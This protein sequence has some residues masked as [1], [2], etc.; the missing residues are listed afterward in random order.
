MA[1]EMCSNLVG[2]W[3]CGVT[4]GKTSSNGRVTVGA[5]MSNGGCPANCTAAVRNILQQCIAN[6]WN[7]GHWQL[8]NEWYWIITN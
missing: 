4:Y 7:N 6:K 1:D 2:Q 3:R 8:G 5:K